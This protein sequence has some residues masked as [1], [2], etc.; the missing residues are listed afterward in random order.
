[1]P[2]QHFC[3]E[4]SLLFS[5]EDSLSLLVKLAT[6]FLEITRSTRDWARSFF[7]GLRAW[8]FRYLVL[9]IYLLVIVEMLRLVVECGKCFYSSAETLCSDILRK[10]FCWSRVWLHLR[11]CSSMESLT[12]L[13][14]MF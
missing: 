12:M 9:L 6:S 13:I 7:M 14:R 2:L 10:H 11:Y 8:N 4:C 3:M 5:R 1:L